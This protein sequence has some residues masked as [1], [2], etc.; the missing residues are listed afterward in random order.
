M[1]RAR[2]DTEGWCR[3]GNCGHKLFKVVEEIHPATEI[4]KIE[5]KCHSCR[6]VNAI[7]R[8]RTDEM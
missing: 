7:W 1:T 6:Y 5:M 4:P 3:C 2:I 8:R